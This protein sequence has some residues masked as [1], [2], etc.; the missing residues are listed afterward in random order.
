MTNKEKYYGELMNYALAGIDIAINKN[1]NK[2]VFCKGFKCVDCKFNEHQG[3]TCDLC[4][5][6]WLNE[7]YIEPEP[8]TD[9]SKVKV[10]TPI[11]V[12]SREDEPWK[13]RYFARYENENEGVYCWFN[14]ATSYTVIDNE[15]SLWFFVKLPTPE[16]LEQYRKKV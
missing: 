15:M 7:E 13:V 2:I 11:L 14:G 3:V 9:W 5:L 12:R 6:K 1:T 8:E 16:E 10:D 4:K